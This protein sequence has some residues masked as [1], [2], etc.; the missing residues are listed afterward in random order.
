M[1]YIQKDEN[2]ERFYSVDYDKNK[3]KEILEK[4]KKYE[5][6]K[7][8]KGE[9]AGDITKWPATEKIIKK[10]VVSSFYKVLSFRYENAKLYP[11]SIVRH[12]ENG[13]DYVTYNYS[14]T[15][16]P[17]L[18]SYIETILNDDYPTFRDNS[19]SF[20]IKRADVA[21]N[22]CNSDQLLLNALLNYANSPELTRHDSINDDKEYDYKGL[23]E[24]YYETLKCFKFNLVAVKE[25]LK[26]AEVVDVFKL[27]LK[28]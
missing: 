15:K 22:Y 28:K 2:G 9:I 24:L 1:E 10:R 11:E 20:G 5:Y 8:A 16:L 21:Y 19:E 18:Y 3:L 4:L 27:Q 23:N 25:Y 17:D 26:E 6:V 12:T 14:Y 13:C 7:I